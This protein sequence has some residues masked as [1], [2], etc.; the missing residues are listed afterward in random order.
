MKAHQYFV[1][2]NGQ[3]GMYQ[4]VKIINLREGRDPQY[5]ISIVI[6]K[7]EDCRAPWHTN[8]CYLGISTCD[9]N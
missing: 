4:A 2:I 5:L 3:A 6:D 9:E 8:N 1:E 7:K